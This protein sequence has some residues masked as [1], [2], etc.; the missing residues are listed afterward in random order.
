MKYET[1]E[2]CVKMYLGSSGKNLW[3]EYN[4]FP[5]FFK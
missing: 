1:F 4:K 3:K 5:K 2:M